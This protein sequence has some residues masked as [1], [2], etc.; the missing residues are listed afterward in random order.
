MWWWL[1]L[2][3]SHTEISWHSFLYLLDPF[4]FAGKEDDLERGHIGEVS[5]WR[6]ASNWV[7]TGSD[8]FFMTLRFLIISFY[9]ASPDLLVISYW[10]S[11]HVAG[12]EDTKVTRENV[13]IEIFPQISHLIYEEAILVIPEGIYRFQVSFSASFSVFYF[14]MHC[15]ATTFTKKTI[16]RSR[17]IHRT[18]LYWEDANLAIWVLLTILKNPLS[19]LGVS[20]WLL[21]PISRHW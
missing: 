3:L 4:S 17:E 11:L 18:N 8:Y 21:F 14:F 2:F 5:P 12:R 6:P 20:I 1:K 16:F 13:G 9:F 10:F 7:S 15:L 19:L